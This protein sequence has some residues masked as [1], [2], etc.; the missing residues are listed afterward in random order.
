VRARPCRDRLFERTPCV[1]LAVRRRQGR[2]LHASPRALARQGSVP[3]SFVSWKAKHAQGTPLGRWLGGRSVREA[4]SSGY[5]GW[6]VAGKL[7]GERRTMLSYLLKSFLPATDLQSTCT[8]SRC[9]PF[10]AA[11]ARHADW[12]PT[13][14]TKR[15]SRTFMTKPIARNTNSVADPP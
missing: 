8:L 4:E 14:L 11:R 9:G 15:R 3:D 1:R 10:K 2:L 12:R 7:P 13:Q 5:R 6:S